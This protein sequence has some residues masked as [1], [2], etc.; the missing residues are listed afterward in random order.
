MKKLSVNDLHKSIKTNLGE[1]F[2]MNELDFATEFTQ[3][4]EY[5][6]LVLN[7]IIPAIDSEFTPDLAS[8]I[9]KDLKKKDSSLGFIDSTGGS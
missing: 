4:K 2:K 5:R 6:D 9:E 3:N 8:E 7:Q 1:E